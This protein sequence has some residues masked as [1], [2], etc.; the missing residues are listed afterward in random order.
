MTRR[1]VATVASA[2]LALGIGCSSPSPKPPAAVLLDQSIAILATEPIGASKVDWT[3]KHAELAARLPP[4]APASAAYPLIREAV[5]ALDDP[6]ASFSEPAAVAARSEPPPA[7]PA[8]QAAPAAQPPIPTEPTVTILDDGVAYV[9]VPMCGTVEPTTTAAYAARLRSG[10]EA[11]AAQRPTGWV[12]ELRF[13]GGGNVWPMLA[14]L[15]PLLGDGV[16][17][18]SVR[19]G[20]IQRRYL[21]E[22]STATLLWPSGSAEQLRLREPPGPIVATDRV[23][24]LIGRWTMS[25]GEFVAVAFRSDPRARLFGAPTAGLTTETT[26]FPLADGSSLTLPVARL[27]DRAGNVV[28]PTIAPDESIDDRAWPAPDDAAAMRARAWAKGQ[29]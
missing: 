17:A 5:A 20:Q 14:G 1:L 28:P 8:S 27:G 10:I 11:A 24:V 13:D 25:S 29:P 26:F 2:W 15:R 12:V 22:G 6:H 9:V 7:E 16:F 19:D 21:V 18:S 4:K 23:A 3:R